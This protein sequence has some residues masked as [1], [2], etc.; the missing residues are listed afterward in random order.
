MDERVSKVFGY[1]E[2]HKEEYIS[3]FQKFV[4]QPSIAAS[5]YGIPEMISLVMASLEELGAEPIKFENDGNPIIYAEIK[6]ES[7]HTI[8]F[9]GHYDVQPEGDRDLWEDDPYGAVIRDGVLYG[10]GSA[11]NKN[12]LVAKLCA[13]DAW[14]K[15]Y[16]KLPCGVKFFL[17]GEEE[18]GSPHLRS[19]A[20]EH[21][22]LLKC[23]GFNWE[24]GS[25]EVGGVPEIA[26]GSKGMLYVQYHVKTAKADGHSRF[27]PV[28]ENAAWRLMQALSTL[29]DE[30]DR[31][32]ID[33][34][35]D[36]VKEPSEEAIAN[37]KNDNVSEEGLKDMFGIDR[38]VN[39]LTG[40]D[41]MKKY[42]FTPTANI[43]GMSSGYTE[44]GQKAIVPC[45]ADAKMDFR[46]VPGQE[47]DRIFELLRAHLDKHGFA[48]VEVEKLSTMPA[49]ST[50]QDSPFFRVVKDVLAKMYEEPIIHNMMTGTTP[51]PI[52]CKEQDIPVAT[53]GCSSETANIHAPNE[54]QHVQSWVDEIKILCAVMSGLGE[55]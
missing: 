11:D 18:I 21:A 43:C 17:E 52:F 7:T 48:D 36:G 10:R 34:F 30:N 41:L 8:G 13:V 45:R 15:A 32:L 1:I 27:A 4:R 40:E 24:T 35:Y 53:F 50:S 42:Y 3:K 29:K 54:H 37:L 51:M 19:F 2:E 5:G 20:K 6:G 47:P 28:V 39:G 46:L 31:I 49:Y 14:K 38:F 16:G 9:Y 22:E 12:G 23:D 44:Q 55:L 33:G 25:K 26:L